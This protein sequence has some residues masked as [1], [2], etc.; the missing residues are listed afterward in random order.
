MAQ[1]ITHDRLEQ[2]QAFPA[3]RSLV[4]RFTVTG[5]LIMLLAMVIAG[6]L[7]SRIVT[8]A[9]IENTAASSAVLVGSVIA[10]LVQNL[11]RE[12]ALGAASI[13]EL[14]ALT[15][16]SA[17]AERFPHVEIWKRGGLVV[18]SRSPHLIGE[19]FTPPA[20]LLRALEGEVSASYTDLKAGEHVARLFTDAFL[21]IYVPITRRGSGEIIAVAEIHEITGPLDRRLWRVQ[22]QSW[23][24]VAGATILVMCGL[25]GVIHHAGRVIDRQRQ[26]LQRRL[27]EIE[28]VSLLNRQLK[29]KVQ[30]AAGRVAE[31][32]EGN[33]RRIGADLHDGPAQLVGYASL[34]VEQARRATT[35]SER[36]RQLSRIEKALDDALRD[37]RG[38]SKGLLSP[39]I[40]HL[41]LG[42]IVDRVVRAHRQRTNCEV[43]VRAG[44]DGGRL[45]PAARLC[46]FRFLQEGLNNAYR[47]SRPDGQA[48]EYSNAGGMLRV[49]VHDRGPGNGGGRDHR[50]APG[51][52][53]TGLRERV[54]SLGGT[55]TMKRSPLGGTLLEMTLSDMGET[56]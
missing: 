12:D 7:T 30:R 20:G 31:L 44:G 1:A 22:S 21:E 41:G 33:L 49:A 26:D 4:R 23:L 5:G 16:E 24:A 2:G 29:Q 17:F 8:S 19:T 35:R 55:L 48:V 47:H 32:S 37:I 15:G 54:E 45:T 28:R 3:S 10:P 9:T 27:N 34:M 11:D 14:D 43:E 52:G 46:V 25:L 13:A 42:E 40:E 56:R 6:H 50:H 36:E 51:L 38:I 53:L 39:E 18:Y